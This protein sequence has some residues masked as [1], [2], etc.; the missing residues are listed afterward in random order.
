MQA[1]GRPAATAIAPTAAGAIAAVVLAWTA[2]AAARQWWMLPEGRRLVLVVA[3]SAALLVVA[4]LPLALGP[5]TRARGG[6]S[7]ALGVVAVAPVWEG[8]PGGPTGVRTLGL[9]VAPLGVA[10][11]AAA[12]VVVAPR[13]SAVRRT[14]LGLTVLTGAV[15]LVRVALLDPARRRACWPNCAVNDVLV[16][17]SSRVTRAVEVAA[18]VVTA[19]AALAVVALAAVVLRDART[20]AAVPVVAAGVA[21]LAYAAP[22]ELWQPDQAPVLT[23]VRCLALV[24]VGPCL[25]GTAAR[26]MLGARAL[27]RA[28]TAWRADGAAGRSPVEEMLRRRLGDARLRLGHVVDGVARA[29][30]GTVLPQPAAD[31]RRTR[32]QLGTDDVLELTHRAPARRVADA[33]DELGPV[34]RVALADAHAAAG[35]RVEL[36]RLD[37]ARER[38]LVASRGVRSRAERDL[39]DGVQHTLLALRWHAVGAAAG[40][41]DPRAAERWTELADALAAALDTVRDIAHGLDPAVLRDAGL[42]VA[43]EPL[44]ARGTVR[45][46]G[47]PPSGGLSAST[48]RAAWDVV[49]AA[50]GAAPVDVRFGP[51]GAPLVVTAALAERAGETARRLGDLAASARGRVSWEGASVRVELPCA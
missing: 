43:L 38:E 42:V 27:A 44:V 35:L 12:I 7:L 4:S 34:A 24:A 25:A 14:V 46:H 16:T 51:A 10:A 47:A 6:A 17:S 18:A 1:T 36:A 33:L 37:A 23:V 11:T 19:A 13:T 8:W 29:G 31:E 9:A 30:D 22:V 49:R 28:V 45:I 26:D 20:V 2:Q 41:P 40:E 50:E 5:S 32:V 3:G 39:H 15:A 21:A 48:Q